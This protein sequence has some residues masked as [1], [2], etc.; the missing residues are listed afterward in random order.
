MKG[1]AYL[2]STA[3]AILNHYSTYVLTQSCSTNLGEQPLIV[4]LSSVTENSSAF[5]PVCEPVK[6]FMAHDFSAVHTQPVQH[7]IVRLARRPGSA[8]K[9][10]LTLAISKV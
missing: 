8:V 5:K 3:R 2:H 7:S 4:L 9:G 1:T 6:P 10:L